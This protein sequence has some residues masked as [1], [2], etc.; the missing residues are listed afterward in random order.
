MVLHYSS[1]KRLRHNLR[2]NEEARFSYRFSINTLYQ[3]EEV[4][5][6]YLWKFPSSIFYLWSA[7]GL[8]IMNRKMN[9]QTVIYS[10]NI[11]LLSN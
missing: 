2:A 6:F 11:I 1:L 10:Q 8:F 3:M 7:L 9:K 4:P 5:F